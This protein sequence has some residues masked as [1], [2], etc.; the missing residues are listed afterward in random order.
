MKIF[1]DVIDA[2]EKIANALV[3][4]KNI[5]VRKRQKIQDAVKDSFTLLNSA[6]NI[7]LHRLGD[8][9]YHESDSDFRNDLR[10][11]D[12][13]EEWRD[14]EREMRMCRSLREVHG[15]IDGFTLSLMPLR[16]GSRDWH[17][18]RTLVDQVLEREG[19]LADYIS[20][21]LR[22]L[23]ARAD[24][25]VLSTREYQSARRAVIRARKALEAERQ[26]LLTAELS[27]LEAIRPK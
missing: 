11:L 10:R 18:V 25:A 23:A 6:V 17:Q 5:P 8:I 27:F 16:L 3:A 7:V 12:N 15:E 24:S 9:S 2:I 14:L 1:S 4:L 13:L 20:R 19:E 26:H 21:A 22:R